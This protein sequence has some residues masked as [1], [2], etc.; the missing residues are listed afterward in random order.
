MKRINVL[1]LIKDKK[2]KEELKYQAQ[3]V[4]AKR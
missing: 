1:Q 2:K 3:L 4:M